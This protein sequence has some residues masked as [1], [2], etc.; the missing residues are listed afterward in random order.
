[1]PVFHQ[2]ADGL[3][4]QI[5]QPFGQ[6]KSVDKENNNFKILQDFGEAQL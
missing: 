5:G 4:G 6:H 3:K 2:R 1:L